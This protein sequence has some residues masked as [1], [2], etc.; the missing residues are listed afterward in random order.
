MAKQV[1]VI[2]GQDFST[3]QEFFDI[4]SQVLIPGA[5][6]GWN[7][8]AF[9]DI[10]RGGFGTPEGGFVILWKNAAVSRDRLGYWETST[11][12][13]T[14]GKGS[15]HARR[16]KEER[17]FDSLVDIIKKHCPGGEE[18]QDGVELVLE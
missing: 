5:D 9:N 4:V 11:S 10:L 15:S 6:W 13:A 3:I 14:P 12:Q 2:D 16:Q 8:N 18:E 17:V 1:Y 7:M